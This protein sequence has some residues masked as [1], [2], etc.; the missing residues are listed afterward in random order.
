MHLFHIRRARFPA[1]F[2]EVRHNLFLHYFF[3]LSLAWLINS[4]T[5]FSILKR[6]MGLKRTTSASA[7]DASAPG[8]SPYPV[9][10]MI[11][12]C[13]YSFLTIEINPTPLILGITRSVIRQSK[14]LD[15]SLNS[16]NAAKPS[17]AVFTS[18]PME[19]KNS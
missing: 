17:T 19:L 14:K 12:R 2:Q 9:M 16:F 13:G 4:A 11:L 3:L 5:V 15:L 6:S 1:E 10:A 8:W 18:Y 7:S